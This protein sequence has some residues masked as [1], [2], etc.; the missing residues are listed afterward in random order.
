MA[1]RYVTAAGLCPNVLEDEQAFIDYLANL[2]S[3]LKQKSVIFPTNDEWVLAVNRHRERLEQFFHFPFSGPEVVG[4]V[5]DKEALY[6][7]AIRLGIAIPRTWFLSEQSPASV[8]DEVPYPCIIKPTEQRSFYDAFREKAWKIHNKEEFVGACQQAA[9][10]GLVAQEIVGRGLADFYSVCSYV[11]QDRN[12]HGVFVGQ[13]LEQYPP[14]FGTGCLVADASGI[15]GAGEIATK[16]IEIL[17]EFGYYGISEI[18][19]I[20]DERDG[21]HKLLDVNTR[22]WKWIG[23]PIASGVDLPW[24]AFQD[25]LG[26]PEVH[27]QFRSGLVWTYLKDYIALRIEGKGLESSRFVPEDAWSQ[28]L[29]GSGHNYVDAVIDG[30]DPAPI[31]RMVQS[32]FATQSYFCAC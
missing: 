20:Y 26:S 16:G 12:A 6:K 10:Y 1:S 29:L 9:G 30:D 5:L 2:G 4:P 17:R 32:L 13:K 3:S 23:L 27:E 18:E 15:D 22:V 8:A 24:L 14:E 28:L 7:S 19:F 25:T 21:Q 11:G 31:G